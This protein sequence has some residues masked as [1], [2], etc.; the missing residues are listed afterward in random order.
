MND[1]AVTPTEATIV[2]RFLGTGGASQV[3]LGHASAVVELNSIDKLLIDCGPGAIQRYIARYGRLPEAIFI[4]HCHLDHISDLESLFAK[5]W[6]ARPKQKIKIFVPIHI[7]PILHERVGNY[8]GALAEGGVNFWEA[9]H[10][11]PFTTQ[12]EYLGLTFRSYPVRHHAPN[13]AFC[14]HLPG[15]FLYTGDTRPIP[16]IISH[17]ANQAEIILHDCSLEGN[18]SHTG[19]DDLLREYSCE[20]LKRIR[21]YHQNTEEER[22]NIFARGINLVSDVEPAYYRTFLL[23]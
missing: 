13:S 2:L 19:L 10:L 4:S 7:V 3:G 20:Q 17:Y 18:P 23:C 1:L 6:F 21:V 8:P 11:I 16:E 14:L 12:F 5:C 9:F 15:H 22:L